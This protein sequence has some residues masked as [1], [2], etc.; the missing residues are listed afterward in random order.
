M[1]CGKRLLGGVQ[2]PHALAG[3]AHP[4]VRFVYHSTGLVCHPTVY[5]AEQRNA[6]RHRGN[7]SGF[8]G[9]FAKDRL[10]S[11]GVTGAFDVEQSS[12]LVFRFQHLHQFHHG[13]AG[14]THGGHAG[15][16][17]HGRFDACVFG[18]FLDEGV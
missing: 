14:A 8:S 17:V 13:L 15:A 5:R 3:T 4:I 11:A 16:R 18:V 1:T 7:V 6:Q 10:N 12:K 9:K 2:E